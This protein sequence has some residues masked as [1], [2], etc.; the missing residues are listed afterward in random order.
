MTK[1]APFAAEAERRMTSFGTAHLLFLRIDDDP[2]QA[3]RAANECLSIRYA[4]DFSKATRR[5]AALGRPPDIA[6]Q[7]RAYHDAGVRH[8]ILDFVG[9]YE[10]RD[11][12][13]STHP[14]K[15]PFFLKSYLRPFPLP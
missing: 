6:A 9:P 8:L 10:D 3:F 5:Y 4:T 13:S 15:G 14:S 7:V 1:I 12:S 2:A 11:Q